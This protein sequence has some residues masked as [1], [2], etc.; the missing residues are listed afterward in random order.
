MQSLQN[1]GDQFNLKLLLFSMLKIYPRNFEISIDDETL[2]CFG[3]IKIKSSNEMSFIQIRSR[4]KVQEPYSVEVFMPPFSLI[5][6]Y[7]AYLE[8]EKK[9]Q[10][11]HLIVCTDIMELIEI[12]KST[13]SVTLTYAN[14]GKVSL[15]EY[16]KS[17]NIFGSSTVCY[18][19]AIDQVTYRTIRRYYDCIRSSSLRLDYFKLFALLNKLL[20]IF[21]VT[22]QMLDREIKSSVLEK[23]GMEDASIFFEK[24]K[25]TPTKTFDNREFF[26]SAEDDDLHIS[27]SE[28]A[29]ETEPDVE[30]DEVKILK[31]VAK[32][33]CKV[34]TSDGTFFHMKTQIIEGELIN[35]SLFYGEVR[36][37]KFKRFT[38]VYTKS[39]TLHDDWEKALQNQS[40]LLIAILEHPDSPMPKDFERKV[41]A[42]PKSNHKVLILSLRDDLDI[43]FY[44]TT[45]LDYIKLSFFTNTE[46]IIPILHKALVSKKFDEVKDSIELASNTEEFQH[47]IPR[48][49]IQKNVIS[50]D[51][52]LSA[53]IAEKIAETEENFNEF[54]GSHPN[55]NIHLLIKQDGK[56]NFVWMKT[57]GRIDK[58]LEYVSDDG[59][60]L[61]EDFPN[62]EKIFLLAD[63]PGNGKYCKIIIF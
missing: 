52:L 26:G 51:I 1:S 37:R 23:F 38:L 27:D 22:E 57:H 50:R 34:I 12:D 60:E 25:Q 20:L 48:K 15:K 33:V 55:S 36:K 45:N 47:Y 10:V 8:I 35:A 17:V 24:L 16:G 18:Q 11:K 29:F 61:K 3:D 62:V 58:L 59:T 21:D 44:D 2:K 6:Y 56:P 43:Q 42:K 14:F 40:N 53:T 19:V 46:Y 5:D 13:S 32:F 41:A 9:F 7:T 63:A 49:L 28:E 39:A 31:E 4:S 30:E 54:R